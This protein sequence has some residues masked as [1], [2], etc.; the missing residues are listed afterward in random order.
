M[1]KEEIIFKEDWNY[2]M[3]KE[4]GKYIFY[5]LCGSSAM[6]EKEYYL[7]S[8]DISDFSNSMKQW[9]DNKAMELRK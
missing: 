2:R 1:T 9:C 8:K 3:M 6:Y 7:T 4:N 5:V